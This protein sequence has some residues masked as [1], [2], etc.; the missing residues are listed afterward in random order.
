M[1]HENGKRYILGSSY[2]PLAGLAPR[3]NSRDLYP[4][5][6]TYVSHTLKKLWYSSERLVSVQF[7]TRPALSLA[8]LRVRYS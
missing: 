5:T 8:S 3:I 7:D 4:G 1:S 6:L 2:P